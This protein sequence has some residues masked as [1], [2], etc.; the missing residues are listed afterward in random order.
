MELIPVDVKLIQPILME[1]LIE[2]DR[3][4]RINNIKYTL[5]GGTMLGAIRHSGFIPWDDDIDI[6]MLRPDYEKFLKVAN[7]NLSGEYFLQ[8]YMTDPNNVLQFTK[9]RKNNTIFREKNVKD[10]DMHHG[11]YLDIFP[12]DKTNPDSIKC[13]IHN[14]LYKYLHRFNLY[15]SKEVCRDDNVVKEKI[16]LSIRSI[17]K[18]IPLRKRNDSL[19]K[20]RKKNESKDYKYVSHF[21]NG[22][23]GNVYKRFLID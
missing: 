8:N 13:K 23:N 22:L 2:V 15:E 9:I 20:L 16:K 3:I 6:A 21:S 4:C 11:F 17:I 19:N 7:E 5:F 12:L 18:L 1:M 10:F 14:K